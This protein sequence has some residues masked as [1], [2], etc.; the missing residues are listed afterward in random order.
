VDTIFLL[1][2]SPL[3]DVLSNFGGAAHTEEIFDNTPATWACY[4]TGN[5]RTTFVSL[6][7]GDG[8]DSVEPPIEP[9]PL[10]SVIIEEANP[11]SNPACTVNTDVAS[12]SG[13]SEIPALGATVADLEARYG[14][15]PVDAA[16]H[17]AYAS[18][19][20]MGDEENWLEHKVIYYRLEDGIVTGIA[21]K[22]YSTH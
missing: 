18:Y 22:L 5:G 17:I 15:A 8:D 16:G 10:V 3:A 2:A 4:E 1:E 12:P 20:E 11:P 7:V 19:Y 14:S 21:Y 6:L 9:G 13:G